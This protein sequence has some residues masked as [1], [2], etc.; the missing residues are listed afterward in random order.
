MFRTLCKRVRDYPILSI[1]L[2]CIIFGVV[3]AI[4]S[5]LL[6]YFFKLSAA[7]FAM[8]AIFVGFVL[9]IASFVICAFLIRYADVLDYIDEHDVDFDVAWLKTKPHDYGEY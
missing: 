3:A 6:L 9:A 1:M 8:I 5:A 2:L 7:D 4:L